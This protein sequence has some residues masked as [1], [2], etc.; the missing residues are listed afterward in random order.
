MFVY[1]FTQTLTAPTQKNT[2]KKIKQTLIKII[3]KG[4][5][6]ETKINYEK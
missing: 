6:K 2:K 1:N 4:T 3:K 5:K